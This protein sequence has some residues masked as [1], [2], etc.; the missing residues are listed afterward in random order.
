MPSTHT[1]DAEMVHFYTGLENKAKL[2][3]VLA[4]LGPAAYCLSYMYGRFTSISVFDQYF[5]VLMKL[6]RH[7][8][9]FELSKMF[10]ISESDVYSGLLYR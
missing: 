5:M 1:N 8:T 6:R 10:G 2:D 4:S 3:T 9:N 7:I